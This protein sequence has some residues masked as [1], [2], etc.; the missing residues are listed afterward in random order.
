MNRNLPSRKEK[1]KG[2][3]HSKQKTGRA[4]AKTEPWKSVHVSDRAGHLRMA[5]RGEAGARQ[6]KGRAL[7]RM[8]GGRA[9]GG[10]GSINLTWG[11]TE[12]R[13]KDGAARQ[14]AGERSPGKS[15][16][17]QFS[18]TWQRVNPDNQKDRSQRHWR[19]DSVSLRDRSGRA[20][21]K[22]TKHSHSLE[23]RVTR[24]SQDKW[25]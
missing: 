17:K 23:D 16:C 9:W 5:A 1:A 15:Y 20:R 22:E 8:T 18:D 25:W 24:V 2:L 13:L 21:E 6:R 12:F 7:K 10:Q 3:W 4:W 19:V 14:E 11:F